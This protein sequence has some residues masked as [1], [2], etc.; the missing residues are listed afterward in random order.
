[1]VLF[2]NSGL[3]RARFQPMTVMGGRD[4]KLRPVFNPDNVIEIVAA[5]CQLALRFSV[6]AGDFV[7][8]VKTSPLT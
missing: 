4:W 2:Q 8:H 1:M 7:C 6:A 5:F 3:S